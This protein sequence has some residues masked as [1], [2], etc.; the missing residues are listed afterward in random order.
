LEHTES[1]PL[2]ELNYLI[3]AVTKKE[4]LSP[5]EKEAIANV[6]RKQAMKYYL[7]HDGE[8]IEFQS[9]ESALTYSRFI[10]NEWAIKDEE[11]TIVFDWVDRTGP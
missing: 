7:L 6:L 2:G 11:G 3:W 5:L 10:V 9:L 8:E 4:C 1:N